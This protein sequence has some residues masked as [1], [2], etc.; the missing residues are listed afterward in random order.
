MKLIDITEKN[1]G[2]AVRLTTNADNSHTL[3]EEFVAS[4]AYSIIQSVYEPGWTVRAIEHD[5][6]LIGFVMYGLFEEKNS[7]EICRFMI[8]RKFQGKGYGKRA[9]GLIVEE[10]KEKFSCD[11]I[12]LS[13]VPANIRGKHV[14]E[15]FGFVSTGEIVED[16]EIYCLDLT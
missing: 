6:V 1:W 13:V 14:Y 12:Y 2:K 4:N 9:L 11:K 16:E 10:M 8:D 5:E 15:K 3:G 7:Y